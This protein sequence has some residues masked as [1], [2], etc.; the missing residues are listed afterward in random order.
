MRA[1][2]ISTSSLLF[3]QPSTIPKSTLQFP[4]IHWSGSQKSGWTKPRGAIPLSIFG[5][6]EIEGSG[7]DESRV[8]DG[9]TVFA[10]EKKK[11]PDL[12]VNDLI[13]N[14]YN[15]NRESESK[16]GSQLDFNGSGLNVNG[17]D[18]NGNK[19][20]IDDDDGD[21]DDDDDGWEF[22]AAEME[23]GIGN[24]D[25]KLKEEGVLES[26]GLKVEAKVREDKE[27]QAGWENMEGARNTFGY[28]NGVHG[29]SDL[30]AASNGISNGS[31]QWDFGFNFN[32]SSM[33][34]QDV[35][36]SGLFPKSKDNDTANV[37]NSSA[38][39]NKVS[40]VENF[41]DFK[42]PFPEIGSKHKLEEPKVADTSPARVEALTFGSNGVGGP[43]D[44]FTVS[45]G[46]SQKS[47]KWDS[48]FNFSPSS[49][50]GVI[51]D[52]YSKSKQ[53]DLVSSLVDENDG[54]DEN[55]WEFKDAFSE[56]GS[57][58]KS[59]EPK[60]AD[61]S[62]ASVAVIYD[63]NGASNPKD[64]LVAS[65]GVSHKSG[66]W[67]FEFN[68]NPT[69]VTQDDV[70][71]GSNSESKQNNLSSLPVDEND[72]YD[73]NFGEF[74]DAFS[75][76]GSKHEEESKVADYTTAVVEAPAFGG[77]IQRNEVRS[78]NHREPLPMSIF[79]DG[80]LES[81]DSS[82]LQDSTF[83]LTSN[84]RSS[85]QSPGSNTSIN[86]L[87]SSL[88]S[89]AKQNAS[90]NNTPK[91]SDH[92]VHSTPT[93]FESDLVN[94]D[95]DFDDDSWDFKA[96]VSGTRAEDQTSDI[97]L[98]DSQKKLSTTLE[99]NDCV[100]F[101]CKL[102][103]ELCLIALC[104]LDNLK[105]AQSTAALS[106][107]E[108]K[109]KALDEE[110]QEPKFQ[111]LESE[112]EL[113]RRLSLAEK[114]IRSAIELL[115]DVASTLTI[116]KL[117]SVEE[118]HYYISTWS[119]IV[120][121][122]AQE[123]KHGALIWNESSQ[124]NVQSQILSEPQGKRYILALGEIYRVVEVLRAS[125]KLYK[126]WIILTS[127][128]TTGLVGL[129]SECYS[130]WASSGLEDALKSISDRI[131]FEY[132]GTIKELLESIKYIHDIDA[133]ALQNHFFSGQQPICRLS[134][135]STGIVPGLRLVVWNGEHYFLTLAN[136]WANLISIDPPI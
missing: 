56:S 51:S 114:D 111:V 35:F 78:E 6:E 54:A 131:D 64:S 58:H 47:G 94:G 9:A 41:W 1:S 61:I 49:V 85:I 19:G 45:N 33:A 88:Y 104:H 36:T 105:K 68:F 133:L 3:P 57:K 116:L 119:K 98:G 106:G 46:L 127:M 87:I 100:D 32:M 11:K 82:I 40:F 21:D 50:N 107:E 13:A 83:T 134:A 126:P 24:G 62:P 128:D 76:T 25:S 38:A 113:S 60:V 95:D 90:V 8:G 43:I 44:L 121:V 14:L 109:A 132:D 42:D 30:F 7:V 71:S 15:R 52:P 120:S 89:Q 103:D 18:S 80:K 28:G 20:F 110:I 12:G 135:L 122:C 66:E 84:P 123:L 59:E 34:K 73:E 67:E 22:K 10:Q 81:D 63:A 136:L 101:Y 102:K 72:E 77:E 93:V 74:K 26:P 65:N 29:P 112:Y 108:A 79:S 92:E 69:Y 124:K 86:D 129:L 125:T 39:D 91:A 4:P 27:I 23:S 70:I 53:N 2:A 117:G 130:T 99:L 17:S 37:V 118:Q 31:G 5:E 97:D 75:E 96:A 48:G 115:K 55:F 16:N